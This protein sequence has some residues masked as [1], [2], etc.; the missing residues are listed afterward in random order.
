[1]DKD[2]ICKLRDKLCSPKYLFP[3]FI[4]FM[5][6]SVGSPGIFLND[7]WMFADQVNQISNGGDLI[8]NDGKY[9]Y[10]E[11]NT[12]SNYFGIRN[13]V[14]VYSL[15]FPLLSMPIHF[16]FNFLAGFGNDISW[17][18][19]AL[20]SIIV[21][22]LL[23][24]PVAKYLNFNAIEYLISTISFIGFIIWLSINRVEIIFENISSVPCEVLSI[25][26]TNMLLFSGLSV[27]IYEIVKSVVDNK[28]MQ[29]FITLATLFTGSL[30]FWATT[31]KDHVLVVV[32]IAL[33]A[34]CFI[35]HNDD[36]EYNSGLYYAIGV[37][38]SGILM[39]VRPEIG[40]GIFIANVIYLVV[41][42]GWYA[43]TM[44]IFCVTYP[45]SLIPFLLN[46]YMVTGN[47]LK[48]PFLLGNSH[49]AQYGDTCVD[50]VG[51]IVA[52]GTSIN[53]LDLSWVMNFVNTFIMPYNGG[54]NLILPFGIFIIAIFYMRKNISTNEKILLVVGLC[55]II[56]HSMS[57]FGG[58]HTDQGILPDM[59]YY[60]QFYC[61]ATIIGLSVLYKRFKFDAKKMIYWFMLSIGIMIPTLLLVSNVFI[62]VFGES[63]TGF[64]QLCNV[65]GILLVMLTIL[66]FVISRNNKD[67]RKYEIYIPA[68]FGL[69]LTLQVILIVVYS[70]V[71]MNSYP[72]LTYTGEFLYGLIFI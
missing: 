30:L 5:L 56:Y 57:V 22:Y 64:I 37:A 69:M 34:L 43:D 52:S 71:K 50:S 58:M 11:N 45:I 47:I 21:A 67:E 46:N 31:C 48:H 44:S 59:R 13:N 24:I 4:M 27:I 29:I 40:F 6:L 53:W 8:Y 28:D 12:M 23:Y 18:F 10:F 7:E 55:S 16:I 14:L 61:F 60:S 42:N 41:I 39:W 9:G 72:F 49:I 62:S 1:M 2:T 70:D 54:M 20:Y 17:V 19:I 51:S 32:I 65:V 33:I 15:A 36:A 38:L 66:S 35:K 26:F 25:C 3:I 63:Y 68:L